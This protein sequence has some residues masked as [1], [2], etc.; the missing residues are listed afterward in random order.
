MN[1][2]N[3]SPVACLSSLMPFQLELC[4]SAEVYPLSVL[5]LAL[6]RVGGDGHRELWQHVWLSW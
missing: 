2:E 4:S 6:A 5:V 1:V 3:D